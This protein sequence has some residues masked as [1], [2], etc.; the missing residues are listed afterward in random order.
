MSKLRV[1]VF[2]KISTFSEVVEKNGFDFFDFRR[3][4]TDD[5]E[6]L[7]GYHGGDVTYQRILKEIA[8]KD[9]AFKKLLAWDVIKNNIEHFGGS[10]ISNIN[11]EINSS[12]INNDILELGCKEIH[13]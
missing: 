8:A 11:N 7:D 5:C 4:S 12:Y 2:A 9:P 1:L 10:T 6:F 13:K 3:I